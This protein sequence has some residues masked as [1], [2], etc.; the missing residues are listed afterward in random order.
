MTT[1]ATLKRCVG[2]GSGKVEEIVLDEGYEVED[3]VGDSSKVE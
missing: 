2:D 3:I 1:A